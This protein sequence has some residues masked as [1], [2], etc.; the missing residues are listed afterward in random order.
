M[1]HETTALPTVLHGRIAGME[2]AYP[3]Y[4]EGEVNND[5]LLA[6]AYLAR[7]G[8]GKTRKIGKR[9]CSGAA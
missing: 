6:V 4:V 3:V 8:E 7:K 1:A 9:Q 2:T 5:H